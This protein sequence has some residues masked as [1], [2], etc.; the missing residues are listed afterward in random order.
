MEDFDGR[1]GARTDTLD[2]V[3]LVLERAGV[4]FL[5]DE[6]PGVKLKKMSR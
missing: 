2:K 4:E 5:N 3:V 1:V 6:Q